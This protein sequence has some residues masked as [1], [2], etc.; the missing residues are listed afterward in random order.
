MQEEP[1]PCRGSCVFSFF[2]IPSLLRDL[3]TAKHVRV[4]VMG[5]YAQAAGCLPYGRRSL[6]LALPGGGKKPHRGFFSPPSD[7]LPL[8][9][10]KIAT[11]KGWLFLW[12]W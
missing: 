11:H 4:L 3:G 5:V 9:A 8:N 6:W 7:S 10:I 2:V 1:R 12:S